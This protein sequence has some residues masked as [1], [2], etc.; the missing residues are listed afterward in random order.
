MN[1]RFT[2]P[3]YGT[4][5]FWVL[6]LTEFYIISRYNYNLFHSLADGVSIVMA[7]CVFTIIWDSRHR[8]DNNYFLYTGIAFLFF[9]FLDLMHLLGNKNM[10]VFPEYG[11]LGPAFYIASRYILSV[12]LMIA[13]LF[14]SRKLNTALAFAAYLLVT[15]LIL[16]SIFYWQIFPACIVEGVGLTAFKVVSDYIICLILLGAIGLL[17]IN[18]RSFDSRVLW[19][20]VASITLFIATGLTFTLYIDP[21]GITNAVGHLFQ[22][23]SFY[24][25]Y[26]AIIE[27]SLTKPQEILFRQL[28]QNEEKLTKNLQ[29]L[30]H[31]N[32][33]LKQE[34]AERK[35]VE[36]E[37]KER[38]RQ[39]ENVNKEL[40]SFSYSVS[41]DLRA[42]LRA[43]DGYTRMILKR[44]L[45][46]FDKETLRQFNVIRDNARSMNQ[47]ID[48]L[49]AF[50]RLGRQDMVRSLIDMESLN[51]EI[52]EK[53]Q[54]ANP[55]RRMNLKL[56]QLPPVMGYQAL[57]KQMRKNILENSFKFTKIRDVALI[58]IGG[59]IKENEI[60][61]YIR[62]NGIGFDMSY[63]DKLFGVFQRLHSPDEY[64]GTGIGLSI[65]QRIIQ[66]HGGRV[67]AESKIDEGACFY[68][69]LPK[70]V[71]YKFEED[72]HAVEMCG[73]L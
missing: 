48:D 18:R 3:K 19:I 6:A 1:S 41:H 25:I 15:S 7:G 58:E 42:P 46:K 57:I 45:D 13:P 55:D 9:A 61:Y 59:F 14:I 51:R 31:K 44:Q 49:L 27:T 4:A 17:L 35:R 66:R 8:V 69:M 29:Q 11:N 47:L 21:F 23:T 22:I 62:D 36:V 64:E 71:E 26:L 37:L 43:I 65:V 38:T 72:K 10:G 60:V 63:Y 56:D 54:E 34:I 30:D 39:L 73:K 53:L 70:S 2:L 40:E 20:I 24:L 12:S 16:L 33:E 52:W 68:F 28:K 5:T 32:L 67:W 50:S